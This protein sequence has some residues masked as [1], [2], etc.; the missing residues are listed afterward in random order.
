MSS[1]FLLSLPNLKLETCSCPFDP[2]NA[3]KEQMYRCFYSAKENAAKIQESTQKVMNEG[4]HAKTPQWIESLKH[5]RREPIVE[6]PFL[7]TVQQCQRTLEQLR[8]TRDL[9][10]DM[11]IVLA[12]IVRLQHECN[13][14]MD[15][16]WSQFY[17]HHPQSTLKR[18]DEYEPF[19]P[20]NTN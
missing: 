11:K 12:E 16:C 10:A 7:A 20:V 4:I 1:Q 5:E 2:A 9:N 17:S 8:R 15:Q 13:D 18:E 3:T 6:D 14:E 19:K